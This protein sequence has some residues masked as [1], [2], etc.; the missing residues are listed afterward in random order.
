MVYETAGRRAARALGAIRAALGDAEG[1]ILATDPDREGEAIAWQVLGWLREKD[2][3]GERP[4]RRVAFHEITAEGV[5]AAM[6][7]PRCLDMDLVRAQQARRALDYLVGYGL[8]PLMW[9]KAPGCRSAGRVHTPEA[10]EVGPA[11]LDACLGPLPAGRE[12]VRRRLEP[13]HSELVEEVRVLEP[14]APLVLVGEE[15][16]VHDTAGRL[17]GVHAHEEGD[18]GGGGDAVLGEHALDLPAARPVALVAHLLPHR[19]LT[20]PVCGDGEGLEGLEVDLAGAIG[21][22]D[23]GRGVAE[24]ETLLDGPLGNPEAGGDVGDGGAVIGERAEGLHLVGRMH[25]H[26][27]HVLREGE[28]AVR[29]TVVDDPAGDGMVGGQHAIAGEGVEGGEPAGAGDDGVVLASLLAGSDGAC[30][31]VLEQPVGGDG[32]LELGEGGLAGLG[33]ADVGGRALQ[34]VERNGSDDG[35]VHVVLR[36]AWMG[37]R[38][39]PSMASGFVPRRPR[40]ISPRCVAGGPWPGPSRCRKAVVRGTR[41]RRCSAMAVVWVMARIPCRPRGL[42]AIRPKVSRQRRS[43]RRTPSGCSRGWPGRYRSWFR[44]SG[45]ASAGSRRR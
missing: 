6:A 14:D 45:R 16:A 29:R 19:H 1:L 9:R 38:P 17:I 44:C 40:S 22:E 37:G 36:K 20:R 23:L 25:C 10:G 34:P 18:R 39:D 24:A 35:I 4:V 26:A 30:H 21:V 13:V 31:E 12:L 42:E 43:R 2:A 27:H 41:A 28:L 15:V 3:L 8:S 11:H 32:G 5:R 33:P 7:L